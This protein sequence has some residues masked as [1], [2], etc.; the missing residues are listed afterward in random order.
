MIHSFLLQI[1]LG[2]SIVKFILSMTFVNLFLSD[3]MNDKFFQYIVT[4]FI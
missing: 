2:V 4:V 3:G 1:Y